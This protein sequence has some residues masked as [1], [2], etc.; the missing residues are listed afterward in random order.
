[1]VPSLIKKRK[2]K[3]KKIVQDYNLTL[4]GFI[5]YFLKFK[6]KSRLQKI[7]EEGHTL[8]QHRKWNH[9]NF[10]GCLLHQVLKHHLRNPQSSTFHCVRDKSC[11]PYLRAYRWFCMPVVHGSRVWHSRRRSAEIFT[12]DARGANGINPQHLKVKAQSQTVSNRRLTARKLLR[13]L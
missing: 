1:M 2:E 11:V 10:T 4:I 3:R 13:N 5:F 12:A 8:P 9:I 6:L 7:F